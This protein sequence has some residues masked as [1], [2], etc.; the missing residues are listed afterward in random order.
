MPSRKQLFQIAAMQEETTSN[1]GDSSRQ[2]IP[3][4]EE[5]IAN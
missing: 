5:I 4:N 2:Q 3:W 1:Q